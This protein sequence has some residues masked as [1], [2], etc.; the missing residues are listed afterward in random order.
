M[1]HIPV[2][3]NEVIE[4]LDS[5]GG[6]VV[7]DGTLGEGGHSLAICTILGEKGRVIG[8]DQDEVA[9]EKAQEKLKGA[10]CLFSAVKGNF[11]DLDT[12][13]QDKEIKEVDGI[14]LDLGLRS[15]H[16]EESGRGFSFR[17]DE[18]LMMTFGSPQEEGILTA[19]EIIN[20]WSEDD[21]AH[22]IKE[23]GDERFARRIAQKI[24][25]RRKTAPIG[26]TAE[27]V[28]VVS[29]SI[30]KILQRG[31]L[32]FATKTFQAIRIAVNDEIGAL[33]EVLEKACV[34]LVPGGKLVV[35]SFHSLEDRTVKHF[36]KYKEDN[37]KFSIITK[38]PITPTKEE[39]NS[40]PRARS[41]KLRALKKN[42]FDLPP[43]YDENTKTH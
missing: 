8:I 23:Y 7:V 43:F 41:A 2:L 3:L 30:P 24:V 26:T 4:A 27:L 25:E 22:I 15:A 36:F 12:I 28:E 40:N 21:L 31:R 37:A 17:K 18:P 5:K 33:K 29:E 6:D 9:I 16:L 38:R 19:Y 39:I 32:H 20:S 1:G 14:F 10:L 35:I 13:L 34:A 42:E 11:R